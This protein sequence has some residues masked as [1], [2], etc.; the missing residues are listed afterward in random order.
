MAL[1]LA[2]QG[3]GVLKDVPTTAAKVER[4]ATEYA[5][6]KQSLAARSGS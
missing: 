1:K 2:A 3:I 4:L 5:A 6:A